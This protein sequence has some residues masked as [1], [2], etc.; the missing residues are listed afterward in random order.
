MQNLWPEF[1]NEQL[2]ADSA[3]RAQK[4]SIP[5]RRRP[6][7]QVVLSTLRDWIL[8]DY[9]IP[10]CRSLAA[11]R[12]FRHCYWIDGFGNSHMSQP[13]LSVSQEL[14]KENK[15]IFLHYIGLE[16]KSTKRKEP[17]A[18][19]TITLPKDSG[20]IRATWHVAAPSLLQAIDQS[21]AIFSLNPFASSPPFTFQDLSP[22][23]Q[24]TAPTELCLLISQRQIEDRL[25]PF[26][27]T[28]DGASAFTALLRNDRWKSLLTNEAV[29]NDVA[30]KL[31]RAFFDSI[32]QQHF[33]TVQQIPLLMHTAPAI[34]E[35]IPYIL[36]FA[37]RRQDSLVCMNDALCIYRRRLHEQSL[38]G[39]LTEAWFS[40]Q[41]REHLANEMQKMYQRVLQQGHVQRQ[42]RWP[43][44][45]Q[46]SLLANFGQFTLH[47][48]DSV[49]QKMLQSG[50]VRCEWRQKTVASPQSDEQRIP[51]SEDILLW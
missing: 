7:E 45:R 2:R 16:S 23:Y 41:Q 19:L 20:S 25:I 22:L 44:L 27:R 48:Y 30:N 34:V 31:T 13:V 9:L 47:D 28:S 32:Q 43:D 17:G 49:I 40:T 24:R 3:S 10:Y 12:I 51:G 21:A 26:L 50:E 39:V 6:T 14:A 11:T 29:M 4:Q 33:L 8:Q 36:I 15:S 37:T 46:Q 38:E 1:D 5:L 35:P 18:G 42:R